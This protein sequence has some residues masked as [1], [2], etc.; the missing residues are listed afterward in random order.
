M[1]EVGA[2]KA[3]GRGWELDIFPIAEVRLG[4]LK[5]IASLGKSSLPQGQKDTENGGFPIG[6]A[7]F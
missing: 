6:T 7:S 5:L 3:F 2:V 1:Q 4:S